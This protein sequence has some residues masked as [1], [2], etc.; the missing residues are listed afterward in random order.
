MLDVRDALTLLLDAVSPLPPVEVSLKDALWRT[1]AQTVVA[2]RDSPPTDR[3]AM[4]GFAVRAADC[5]EASRTLCV[6][7]EVRAGQD[8]GAIVVGA[9]EAVRVFTGAMIPRGADAVVMQELACLDP[10]AQT[11]LLRERPE[12]GQ[13]IRRRGEDLRAGGSVCEPGAILRAAEIAAL[14][15]VGLTRVR[16]VPPPRVAVISTGDEMLLTSPRYAG[17]A[18]HWSK[19]IGFMRASPRD[20]E[21][22]A[23]E[24]ISAVEGLAKIVTG[25]SKATLGESIKVLRGNGKLHPALAKALEGLYGFVN[26]SPGVRH[27]SD[28]LPTI[29]QGEVEFVVDTAKAAIRMLLEIDR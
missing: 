3:S 26:D 28:V 23:K 22:A 5:L 18:R 8:P 16:V 15:A 1:L 9:G 2:D 10:E 19:A 29:T 6:T 27:G 20:P 17:P 7:E 12:A 24:A 14:T 21:N 4:D 13:H 25:A 11:V